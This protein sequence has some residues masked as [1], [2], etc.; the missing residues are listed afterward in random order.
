[1]QI[2]RLTAHR[3]QPPADQPDPLVEEAQVEGIALQQ[4]MPQGGQAPE[5]ARHGQADRQQ[6][7]RWPAAGVGPQGQAPHGRCAGIRRGSVGSIGQGRKGEGPGAPTHADPRW[8]P[9]R[10]AILGSVASFRQQW[11]GA[12]SLRRFR[13]RHRLASSKR[14]R[15]PWFPVIPPRVRRSRRTPPDTA[16]VRSRGSAAARTRRAPPA[17]FPPAGGI[18]CLAMFSPRLIQLL[19]RSIPPPGRGSGPGLGD[20]LSLHRGDCLRN[21]HP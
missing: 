14:R 19:L 15:C 13:I 17:G 6:P 7:L 21:T 5:A 18:V 4:G 10:G 9:C 8:T 11:R 2:G 20:E 1:M 16:A 12:S 3:R